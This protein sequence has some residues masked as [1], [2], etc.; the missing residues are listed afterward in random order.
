MRKKVIAGRVN[1]MFTKENTKQIKGIAIILMM[2]HHLLTFPDKVPYGMGF[3]TLFYI[4][5]KEILE[6]IGEF[7]K[8]C[9]SLYMFMGGYGLYKKTVTEGKQIVV[10]NKL[11]QN[12]LGLYQAYWKVFLI[13]VPIGFLFF[14]NQEQYCVDSTV[15]F[16]FAEWS[17][18]S[19]LMNFVGMSYSFNSEWWFLWFYLFALF[20][21]YVFIEIFKNK[22]NLY[23][24]CAAIIVWAILLLNIFPIIPFQEGLEPLW[25]NIWYKYIFLGSEYSIL[26][27]VGIVAAKYK[28]FENWKLGISKLKQLEKLILSLVAIVLI[29]YVR[30]FFVETVFDIVLVPLFVFACTTFLEA[31]NIFSKP[32]EILGSHSTNMWLVHTFY[33]FYFE[34]FAKLV[35][36]SGNAIIAFIILLALSLGTSI[37]LN[38]F[39]KAVGKG[40]TLLRGRLR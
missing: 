26:F 18:E 7:S 23:S 28:V 10:E 14:G 12:I 21:G 33:C 39:W 29:I 9:V 4:S 13:F 16:R 6:L 19:F 5:G 15:C 34:P 35:Y 37:L 38:A 24:E 8:I 22:R 20:E 17:L 40:Y 1:C 27:F 31:T 2:V 25:K 11:A 32:L 36:S 3:E 30:V